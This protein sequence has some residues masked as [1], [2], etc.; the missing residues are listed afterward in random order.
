MVFASNEILLL[1]CK[2]LGLL[3]TN[4]CT[5]PNPEFGV[6]VVDGIIRQWGLGKEKLAI[7]APLVIAGHGPQF[8]EQRASRSDVRYQSCY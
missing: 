4:P 7:L 3:L 1:F 2:I 5:L 6:P 8:A